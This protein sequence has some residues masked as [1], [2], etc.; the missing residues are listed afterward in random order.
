M[1]ADLL[2]QIC[3]FLF[4]FWRHYSAQISQ[5][6]PLT[7]LVLLCLVMLITKCILAENKGFCWPDEKQCWLGGLLGLY[8]CRQNS[9]LF[10][11]KAVTIIGKGNC[12]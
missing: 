1:P 7:L 5:I 10:E 11:S 3:S 8:S 6:F 12:R 9:V 4:T 2:V